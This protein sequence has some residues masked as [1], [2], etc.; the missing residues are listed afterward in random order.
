MPIVGGIWDFITLDLT[1]VSRC[2]DCAHRLR[3]K[4]DRVYGWNAYCPKCDKYYYTHAKSK[5]ESRIMYE[6]NCYFH[7]PRK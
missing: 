4:Y 1:E 7:Y 5:K 6:A 2:P 3:F